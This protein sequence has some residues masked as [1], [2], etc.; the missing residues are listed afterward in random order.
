ML[1]V[2]ILLPLLAQAGFSLTIDVRQAGGVGA[3]TPVSFP[4][5]SPA[6]GGVGPPTPVSFPGA[7]SPA[8]GA[9]SSSSP[10][11]SSVPS[12]SMLPSSSTPPIS[13]LLGS[14][15]P[16]VSSLPPSSSAPPV[17]SMVPSSSHPPISSS[18]YTP[19][20]PPAP[21][22]PPSPPAPPTPPTPPAPPANEQDDGY[23]YPSVKFTSNWPA[24]FKTGETVHMEWTGGSGR[25]DVWWLESWKDEYDCYTQV[26]LRLCPSIAATA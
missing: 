1:N 19:P 6:Q 11:S 16:P 24:E 8:G 18:G 22:T 14:S 10:A 4:P 5:S 26:Y 12:S 23:P 17:S 21:P 9:S 15:T 25:Y 2:L 7:L 3:P 20:T 13:S